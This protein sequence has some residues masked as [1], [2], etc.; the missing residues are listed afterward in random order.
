MRS[1][2]KKQKKQN[3]VLLYRFIRVDTDD[4]EVPCIYVGSFALNQQRDSFDICSAGGKYT[5]AAAQIASLA[6]H[7]IFNHTV[8]S[9]TIAQL[10]VIGEILECGGEKCQSYLQKGGNLRPPARRSRASL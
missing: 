5:Q 8:I 2:K 1:G 7:Q 6:P 3:R 10:I 4:N 9:T